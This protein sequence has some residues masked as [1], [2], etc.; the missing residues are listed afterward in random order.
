MLSLL[1]RSFAEDSVHTMHGPIDVHLYDKVY[2]FISVNESYTHIGINVMI[3]GGHNGPPNL[4]ERKAH[5]KLV[6]RGWFC[7]VSV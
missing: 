6:K 3:Q 5:E 2:E 4:S 1:N 7:R